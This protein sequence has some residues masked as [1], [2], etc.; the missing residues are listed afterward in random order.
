MQ[1][2]TKC[3]KSLNNNKPLLTFVTSCYNKLL[4]DIYSILC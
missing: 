3:M 1:S 2:Y 4:T